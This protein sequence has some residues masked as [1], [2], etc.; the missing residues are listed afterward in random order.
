MMT[1]KYFS[2]ICLKIMKL[3]YQMCQKE[4][5]RRR[6]N[7]ENLVN[8]RTDCGYKNAKALLQKQYRNP[9]TILSS[10][11]KKIKLMEP[12]KFEHVPACR[13]LFNFLNKYQTM[14][15]GSQH[16][17]LDTP[18]MICMILAKLP[19]HL[20]DRW[21]RNTVVKEKGFKRNNTDRHC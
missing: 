11:R 15:V 7:Q 14:G 16:N 8:D 20:Q 2:Q 17:P 10:N 12:L 9:H 21:N 4:W 1:W 18:E 13:R 3:P 5:Q 19:L 6:T